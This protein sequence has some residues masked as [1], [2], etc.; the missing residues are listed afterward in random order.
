MSDDLASVA[1]V[2]DDE[3]A[4]TILEAA[5][6][7]PRSADELSEACDA[8][9]STVYRRIERLEATG[10]LADRQRI[11]PDGHHHKVYVS[12]L[13]RVTVDLGEDGFA[14]T[15]ERDRDPDEDAVDRFTR[16]YE[17]FK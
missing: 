17:G 6:D 14:C 2:L 1:A 8:S 4:R 13:T 7:E 16:L 12:R 10:L 5:R 11:D 3:Y 15:V 9:P